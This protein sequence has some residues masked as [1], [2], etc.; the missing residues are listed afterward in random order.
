MSW[1][2][3]IVDD[4]RPARER[5][6]TLLLAHSDMRVVAE[7]DDGNSALSRLREGG[8][9]LMLLD[10]QMPGLDGVAVLQAI[11]QQPGLTSILIT[12]SR[13]HAVAAYDLAALDYVLKPVE[14]GRLAAALERARQW[15]KPPAS[16]PRLSRMLVKQGQREQLV[17]VD[18]IDWIEADGN[19]VTLHCGRAQHLLRESIGALEERLPEAMFLRV[20]RSTLV[21]LERIKELRHSGKAL[22]LALSC[23]KVL[24]VTCG[25]R[26]LRER[27]QFEAR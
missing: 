20:N 19:Y 22:H 5:L 21:N 6:R 3:L 10:V 16:T 9:D 13:E 26:E 7:A 11:Q 2:I 23:D 4:E 8:I 24:N 14:A 17:R 15:M 25:M 18:D 1:S 27:L 12:A